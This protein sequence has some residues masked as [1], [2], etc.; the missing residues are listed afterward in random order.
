[1][2]ADRRKKL[3]EAR[4]RNLARIEKLEQAKQRM[5]DDLREMCEITDKPN[6]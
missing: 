1:M 5:L 2:I 6:P 4:A 3:A